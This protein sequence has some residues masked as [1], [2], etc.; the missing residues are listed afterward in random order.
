MI[1]LC[2]S[3]GL[4]LYHLIFLKKGEM[5]GHPQDFSM[6]SAIK[7]IAINQQIWMCLKNW[8]F[9]LIFSEYLKNGLKHYN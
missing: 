3:Y 1:I 8:H 2:F 4:I 7:S 6:S 9:W 5:V